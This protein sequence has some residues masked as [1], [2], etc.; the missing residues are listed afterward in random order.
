MH[1]RWVQK[2]ALGTV[3]ALGASFMVMT[4]GASATVVSDATA[5]PN[6]HTA[7]A[8]AAYAVAFTTSSTGSLTTADTITLSGPAGTVFP[9]VA[10][11]LTMPTARTQP[12]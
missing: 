10:L 5:S 7:G 3:L 8:H 12:P 4:P 11:S 2:I 1:I 9:L 6:P